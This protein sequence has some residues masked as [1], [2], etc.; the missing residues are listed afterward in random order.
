MKRSGLYFLFLAIGFCRVV[1]G[2]DAPDFEETKQ[3]AEQGNAIAQTIL[4]AMYSNGV[5]VP[6]NDAEGVR[7]YR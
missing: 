3:L 6:E 5:G 2:Q 4:G 1:S 7:W